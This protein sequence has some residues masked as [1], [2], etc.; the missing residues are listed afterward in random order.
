MWWILAIFII[1]IL[2]AFFYIFYVYN[3]L[4]SLKNAIENTYNQIRVAMK[5]R[6]DMIGQLVDTTKSYLKYEKSVYTEVT[7]LRKMPITTPEDIRKA[8]EASRS[9]LGRLFAVMENY[10]DVKGSENV[11]EL[12]ESIKGVEDEIARQ[13]YLYN[14]QVQ[15]FNI[16]TDVFPSNII[17]RMFNFKKKEYLKFGEEIEKRPETK[18]Y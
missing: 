4:V 6:F 13:R 15:T 17:A 11:K 7:R 3:R 10:P 1:I 18:V 14:D 12:Q 9:I 5:K 16:I 8:D 2:A